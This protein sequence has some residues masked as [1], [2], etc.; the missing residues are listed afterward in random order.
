MRLGGTWQLWHVETPYRQPH[1]WSTVLSLLQQWAWR[2]WHLERT[3]K[4]KEGMPAPNSA[5]RSS[6][7][8]GSLTPRGL[9]GQVDWSGLSGLGWSCS[10][11]RPLADSLS[12]AR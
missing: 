12:S 7:S 4:S 3:P 8:L 2:Q 9:A 1:T 5:A 11:G 6:N 10:R